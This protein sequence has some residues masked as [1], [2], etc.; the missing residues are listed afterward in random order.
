LSDQLSSYDPQT[1]SRSKSN[2]EAF[3]EYQEIDD[4][5]EADSCK[6]TRRRVLKKRMIKAAG[7]STILRP[8]NSTNNQD[9]KKQFTIGLI[10]K[11]TFPG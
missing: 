7:S 1:C 10:I 8:P 3:R 11:I 2:F 4:V 9:I 6:V 5:S